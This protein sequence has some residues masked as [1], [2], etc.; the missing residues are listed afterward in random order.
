MQHNA[1]DAELAARAALLE[2]NQLRGAAA[3]AP[4]SVARP[5]FVFGPAESA[6]TLLAL[7]RTNNFELRVRA[8]ELAQ[9]GF[10]VAL[11]RNE[12]FPA[13]NIGPEFSED[14]GLERDRVIGVGVSFPLPLWN[15]NTAN[16]E[17]AAARQIQAETSFAVTQ[18]EIERKV[19]EAA[20]AYET[21]SHQISEWR[22]DAVEHFREA[23]ELADRHYR[24]GAVE[25]SIYVELQ[26]QYLE[27]VDSLLDTQREALEAAQDLE[28]LTGLSHPLVSTRQEAP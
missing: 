3:D 5:Q 11:A 16:I 4:L 24:L 13:I 17:T 12:R 26:K 22:P 18:R 23:A 14:N 15:R 6:D 20:L 8:V 21:K 28:L 1:G 9:Q 10:R 25:V 19:M 27:A 7:A 2:L